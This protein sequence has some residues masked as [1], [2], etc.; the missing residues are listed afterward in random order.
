MANFTTHD[1]EADAAEINLCEISG[2][3]LSCMQAPE[4]TDSTGGGVGGGTLG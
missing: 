1:I 3:M 4:C 2:D